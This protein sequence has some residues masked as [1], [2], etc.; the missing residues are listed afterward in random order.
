MS[1][2]SNWTSG[3][4]RRN[5]NT[6]SG[7]R[8]KMLAM[9]KPMR[10][11]PA[12]PLAARSVNATVADASPIRYR[13]RPASNRPASVSCTSRYPR[14]SSGPPILASI[15]RIRLLRAGCDT[16]RRSAAR[17]KCNVSASTTNACR[18]ASSM[19]ITEGYQNRHN[20]SLDR[21]A[22]VADPRPRSIHDERHQL[23][24]SDWNGGW[25]LQRDVVPSADAEGSPAG[26]ARSV[27]GHADVAAVRRHAVVRL[28]RDQPS[29]RGH[30]REYRDYR[31][32][33]DDGD[34][35]GR[36]GAAGAAPAP[37]A[38]RDRHGRGDG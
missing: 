2:K 20:V 21:I 38:D 22:L 4:A 16:C 13:P 9:P 24:C 18:S 37:S 28:R 29:H 8:P 27:D 19:F 26:W 10:K 5:R 30:G 23:E 36:A 14:T 7:S 17:P 6:T 32:R 34:H 35:E 12:S 33:L 11:S 15:R 31:S 25:H 1:R 3:C